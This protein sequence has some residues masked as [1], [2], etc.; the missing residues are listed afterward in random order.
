M[1]PRLLLD[2][3]QTLLSAE[4]ISEY[5]SK[6][7]GK[8]SANLAHHNMDNY[9]LV[10]E[11]PGLQPFLDFVF[12]NFEVSIWTAA[13]LD[14]ALFIIDKIIVPPAKKGSRRLEHVFFSYHCTISERLTKSPKK[15]EIL[16]TKFGLDYPLESTFIIDDLD[17]VH[18]PQPGNCIIAPEFQLTDLDSHNDKFL[19]N[20]V[21]RLEELIQVVKAGKEA[22]KEVARI[23]EAVL[24][25]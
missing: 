15:L 19:T 5:D 23:N 7:H 18:I 8:R 12:E 25:N 16:S 20:L 11:R 4:P 2:L 22:G 6:K 24:S 10:F 9:Y 17:K 14:Y 13:S 3:D 1:R 21:K